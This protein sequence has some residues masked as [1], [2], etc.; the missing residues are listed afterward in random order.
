MGL[1]TILLGIALMIPPARLIAQSAGEGYTFAVL[2]HVRGGKD[3]QLYVRLAELLDEVRALQPDFVVLTGD[4]VWG[5]VL[6]PTPDTALVRREWEELDSA[7]ATLGVP[8]HR[9][10]GNHDII[11]AGTR[12]LYIDR[13]GRLP[14]TFRHGPDLF[15]LLSSAWI[16]EA[17]EPPPEWQ[18]RPPKLDSAQV[19]FVRQ[20]LSDSALH[21]HAFVFIHHLLWWKPKAPWWDDVHPVL[22]DGRVR[23]VFSGDY[24][25]MKFSTTMRDSVRYY[26]TSVEGDP[27]LGVLRAL[28]SSRLLTQQFDNFL[29]VSV[30]GSDV[31]VEVHTFGEV[32]SK[33]FTP[34]HWSDVNDY[35]APAPSLGE[36]W[37]ML[38]RHPRKLALLAGAGLFAVGFGAV[39]GWWWRGRG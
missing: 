13:Y 6:S 2:G 20:A 29:L 35:V 16:P 37:R 38:L 19:D 32:S 1:L 39:A 7:L 10:P 24:G 12:D 8:V 9:V 25:P 34:G 3:G 11:S 33:H 15:V 27:S 22:A 28:E 30:R 4:M 21:R 26:Q 31:N 18:T 17:D 23:A 14:Q 36:R 5:D